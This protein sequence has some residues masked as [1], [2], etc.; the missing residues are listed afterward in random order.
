MPLRLPRLFI[1]SSTE[2]LD[3]ANAVNLSL[4]H[5]AEVTVWKDGFKLSQTSITSL[6]QLADTVDFA[7]FIFTPDDLTMMRAAE[8]RV[9]RDNVLFELGLFIGSLGQRRCIIVK[10]RNED[11]HFPSD[12]LGLSPAEYNGNRTDNNLAAAVNPACSLI[13]LHMEEVGLRAADLPTARKE[14]KQANLSYKLRSI[15]YSLLAKIHEMSLGSVEGVS[16]WTATRE[17][18]EFTSAQLTI[19]ITKLEKMGY[20]D[21]AVFEDRDGA[22]Y[23]FHITE[24]G[25]TILLDNE[26]YFWPPDEPPDDDIPF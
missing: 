15:D 8:K 2:S 4:D 25:M 18:K 23:S 3:V 16:I 9:V 1:A 6:V 14:R 7:A 24:D 21:K 5:D 11:L 10:P 12:L 19:S 26:R 13:K 20:I 22:F 17:M